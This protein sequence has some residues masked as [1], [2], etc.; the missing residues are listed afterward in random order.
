MYAVKIEFDTPTSMKTAT[1]IFSYTDLMQSA[2]WFNY[3]SLA[4]HFV[5][6]VPVKGGKTIEIIGAWHYEVDAD[7]HEGVVET[8]NSGKAILIDETFELDIG[9]D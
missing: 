1:Q 2:G 3:L 6:P 8:I 7:S 4:F 5:K 9:L